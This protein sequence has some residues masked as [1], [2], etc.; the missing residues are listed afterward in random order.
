[1]SPNLFFVTSAFS[2]ITNQVGGFPWQRNRFNI[3]V[4]LGS[5]NYTVQ[6]FSYLSP[7]LVLPLSFTLFRNNRENEE[8]VFK[9]EV[10]Q[11]RGKRRRWTENHP[12]ASSRRQPKCVLLLGWNN[13]RTTLKDEGEKE[14]LRV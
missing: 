13:F 5:L 4:G 1:M 11:D 9:L 3:M 8:K 14:G 12:F 6:F 10:S 7:S 2:I